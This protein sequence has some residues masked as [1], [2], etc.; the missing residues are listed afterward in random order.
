MA[1]K[2]PGGKKRSF[3]A[4]EEDP[5]DVDTDEIEPFDTEE[6]LNYYTDV[7]DTPE[8]LDEFCL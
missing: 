8:N 6:T 7:E 1:S 4:I 2:A 3:S 5:E